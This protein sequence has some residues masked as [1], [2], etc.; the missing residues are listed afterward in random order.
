VSISSTFYVQIFRTNVVSAVRVWLWTNYCTKNAREKCWWNW[1][2]VA[3][4]MYVPYIIMKPWEALYYKKWNFLV[5]F[6]AFKKRISKGFK[7]QFYYRQQ[8]QKGRMATLRKTFIQHW[9]PKSIKLSSPRTE[10]HTNSQSDHLEV[11]LCAVWRYQFWPFFSCWKLFMW[12]FS[13]EIFPV[14]SR[15]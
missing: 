4:V 11:W 13:W 15:P 2:Q 5:S 3:L 7:S 1:R 9:N 14:Q 8:S 10:F 12:S 6:Y